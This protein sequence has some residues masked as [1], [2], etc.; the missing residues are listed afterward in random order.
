MPAVI[1]VKNAFV[2]GK[3]ITVTPTML[4]CLLGILD[5]N[6]AV[7]IMRCLLPQLGIDAFGLQVVQ[8]DVV[9]RCNTLNTMIHSITIITANVMLSD[10]T[11]EQMVNSSEAQQEGPT[12]IDVTIIANSHSSVESHPVHEFHWGNDIVQFAT[13]CYN[14]TGF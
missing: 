1:Y 9:T 5:T 14:R 2:S 11:V 6:E 4:P 8:Y 12:H 7:V 13:K 3:I 10:E